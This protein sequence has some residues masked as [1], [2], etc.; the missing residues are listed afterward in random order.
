MHY[1][2]N[3]VALEIPETDVMDQI[4]ASAKCQWT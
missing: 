3:L 4:N 1:N 2:N